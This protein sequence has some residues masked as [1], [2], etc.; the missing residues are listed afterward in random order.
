MIKVDK[1]VPHPGHYRAHGR[2]PKYPWREMKVGDSFYVEG[3]KATTMISNAYQ[4]G[5][6]LGMKF[7]VRK[8]D[9]GVRVWRMK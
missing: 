8:D 9:K 7:S 6:R 1:K 5:E 2:N 4:T 3:V